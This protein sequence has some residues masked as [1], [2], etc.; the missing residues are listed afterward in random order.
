MFSDPIQKKNEMTNSKANIFTV[1]KIYFAKLKAINKS[2][3]EMTV[4][5]LESLNQMDLLW[6]LCN[7]MVNT[8]KV[9]SPIGS[10]FSQNFWDFGIKRWPIFFSLPIWNFK[11][12][13]YSLGELS[14][15]MWPNN[16]YHNYFTM[17]CTPW[18]NKNASI[19]FGIIFQ[20]PI[21]KNWKL[22]QNK[23]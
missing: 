19:L 11:I 3:T 13:R 21:N 9:P 7:T 14:A 15:K 12:K 1:S 10:T 8:L 5:Q 20:K 16:G 23:N 22:F 17:L 2:I 18:P 4:L 6:N